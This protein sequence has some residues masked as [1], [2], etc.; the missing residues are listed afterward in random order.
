MYCL[1][2]ITQPKSRITSD[3]VVTS[4][5]MITSKSLYQWSESLDEEISKELLIDSNITLFYEGVD[6][7][8]NFYT[9]FVASLP[10]DVVSDDKLDVIQGLTKS[11]IELHKKGFRTVIKS[12]TMYTSDQYIKDRILDLEPK[13]TFSQADEVLNVNVTFT[14]ALRDSTDLIIS[15]ALMDGIKSLSLSAGKDS[16]DLAL[17]GEQIRGQILIDSIS[18]VAKR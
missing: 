4:I 3:A 13:A 6:L 18:K 14:S 7:S 2:F 11:E 16:A 9:Q 10:S 8:V 15:E 12:I 17:L 1:D 5:K